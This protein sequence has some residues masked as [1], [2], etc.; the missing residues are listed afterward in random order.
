MTSEAAKLAEDARLSLVKVLFLLINSL[1]PVILGLV[2]RISNGHQSL[3]F[4]GSNP[5]P[6]TPQQ[7]EANN[8]M[9]HLKGFR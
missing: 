8:H 4:N 5:P 6:A 3:E 9:P 2:P 1:S 7:K